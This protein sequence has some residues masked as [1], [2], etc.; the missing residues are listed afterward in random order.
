MNLHIDIE[1]QKEYKPGYPI[2]KRGI[3]YLARELSSQLSL[4]TEDTDYSSLSK[5]YSIW[6][7]RDGV[8]EDEQF[9]ISVIEMSNTRNYGK[10]H[11]E[12]KDYDLLTLVIIR[13]GNQIFREME[14]DEKEKAGEY[15][16]KNGMLEFLHAIMYPHKDN[17]LETVKKY[18]DFSENKELWREV[19]KMTGLGMKIGKE[20]WEEG[21]QV[22]WDEGWDEGRQ[23]GWDEGQK[24]GIEL[25]ATEKEK[26]IAFRMFSRNNPLENVSDTLGIS[27]DYTIELH[28][29]Y[30]HMVHEESKY[31]EK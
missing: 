31:G 8:P 30:E 5:C 24:S 18:I 28:Q 11:P 2:E 22:G 26:S 1:P 3:Y 20:C 7:C 9:S 6:V 14:N 19:G 17:F 10:C 4:V 27:M 21:R 12:K 23:S 29:Q 25:G 15:A 13:L 16:D